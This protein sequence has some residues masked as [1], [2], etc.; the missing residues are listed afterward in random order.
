[1]FIHVLPRLGPVSA[2][3]TLSFHRRPSILRLA[4]LVLLRLP[5]DW[6]YHNLKKQIEKEIVK[7]VSKT[8]S[9]KA[10]QGFLRSKNCK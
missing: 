9:C 8:S 6:N 4:F 7:I 5:K 10:L 2:D 3:L 1:M